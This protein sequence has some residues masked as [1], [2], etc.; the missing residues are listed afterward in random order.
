MLFRPRVLK[1]RQHRTTL[2]TLPL[3]GG[4]VE[5]HME[6]DS[7][8]AAVQE[9][10]QAERESLEENLSFLAGKLLD[11]SWSPRNFELDFRSAVLAMATGIFARTLERLDPEIRSAVRKRGHR[12]PDGT[13]CHGSIA[14]K[15]RK[16]VTLT[17]LLGAMEIRRGTFACPTCGASGGMLD[18][19][20]QATPEHMTPAC[21]SVTAQAAAVESY[22]GSAKLIRDMSGVDLDPKRI[23]RVVQRVGP[24]ASRLLE[25]KPE[26]LSPDVETLPPPYRA[27]YASIDGGRIRMRGGAWREPYAGAVWWEEVDGTLRRFAFAEIANKP[28]VF[29]ILDSWLEHF[30]RHRTGKAIIVADGAPW[31]WEWAKEHPGAVLVLDYYH[32]K[33]NVWG[34]AEVLFGEGSSRVERWTDRVMSRIWRGWTFATVL[35]LDRTYPQGENRRRKRKALV[36]LANYIYNHRGLMEYRRLRKRGRTIGSG[37]IESICRQVFSMRLKGPGMFWSEPGAQ[38]VMHLRAL[39]VSGRWEELWS[40][41]HASGYAEIKR[42]AA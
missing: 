17:T 20:L 30:R 42:S 25:K 5:Q 8:R 40:D 33:K 13:I 6:Q 41:I 18:E 34:A 35:K 26:E 15:G 23:H 7:I 3:A 32:L 28:K 12:A 21:V 37:Q 36:A 2:N 27:L 10:I 14:S 38:N 19:I 1:N 4:E 31:I 11:G 16:T 24:S 22:Q 39:Y 9:G 29:G